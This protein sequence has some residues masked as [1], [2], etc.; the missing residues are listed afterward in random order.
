MLYQIFR[1]KQTCA[2]CNGATI[3][4]SNAAGTPDF[5]VLQVSSS[6]WGDHHAYNAN[7]T[8]NGVTLN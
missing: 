6:S 8:L 3:R 1:L 4:R 7:L 5:V 2:G